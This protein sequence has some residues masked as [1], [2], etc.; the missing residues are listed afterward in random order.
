V[1]AHNIAGWD[2][3]R[4]WS[5]EEGTNGAVLSLKS[6][7]YPGT[8][9]SY[10]LIAGGL[11]TTAGTVAA[12]RIARWN[13]RPIVFGDDPEWAAMGAGFNNGVYAIERHA[14]ATYAGGTF[15]AS[16]AT[17]VNRIARWN[18]T[19]AVWEPMGTGMNGTVYAL[20]S[21]GG[22][23]YAG[24]SFTTAGGVSTGGLARWNGTSWSSV[25]LG[26]SGVVYALEIH[27]NA[28]VIAGSFPGFSGSPNLTS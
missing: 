15:T 18:V 24:G 25:G 28:L 19:S 22:S 2:G 27:N 16:G 26:F 13:E 6:H 20:K 11:F 14:S 5:Y 23:L 8:I 17:T 9:G 3:S 21:F 7:K 4:L 1:P 10:E 12:N